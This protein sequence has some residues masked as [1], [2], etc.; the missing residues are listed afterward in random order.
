MVTTRIRVTL[1]DVEPTVVRVIDVPASTSLP[2]LHHLLQAALG[3][4]DDH[5]HQF[6]AGETVWGVPDPDAPEEER[7]EGEA[8]L[9]DL[10]E[11]FT[12]L[13]DFG[14]YWEHDVEVLGVG[15]EQP[16]CADGEGMCP[17]EDC[18]GSRGYAQLLAVL[19]DPSHPEH[20]TM[21]HWAGELADFDLV[22]ADQLVREVVGAVPASVRLVLDLAEGGVS[23]TPGGR[24]RRAFVRQVQ[25]QR[26]HWYPLER[27]AATEDD[28]R[29]LVELH[30]LLR[31][32][33]L[34]RLNKG[35]LK[36]T[37]AAAD[38][39]EVIRRLRSWFVPQEFTGMVVNAVV[40][41]LAT[42]G[43]QPVKELAATV[44]RLVASGWAMDGQPLTL[45]DTEF[46]MFRLYATLTGL[47]LVEEW[48]RTWHPG[49]SAR[50]LMPR[51]A[52]LAGRQ[53]AN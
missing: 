18:G 49:D 35:V 25:D 16:G 1:R 2:E 14:D 28:L 46:L 27:P 21:R 53:A 41:L 42:T 19:A 22:A 44:H 15:A 5:L 20:T 10:P 9:Q 13:Y 23:L 47:D 34:L 24:L 31:K 8:R 39:L 7:D 37:K 36:P 52:L 50:S 30:H 40:G 3:W 26:P 43:A 11:R 51:P 6:V 45:E 29:P 12:Y 48:G 4:A 33:G 38:D 32:V 17:P